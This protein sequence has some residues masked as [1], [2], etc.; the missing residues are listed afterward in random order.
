MYTQTIKQ[1]FDNEITTYIPRVPRKSFRQKRDSEPF[2]LLQSDAGL[3]VSESEY[4][5]NYYHDTEVRYEWNNGRLEVKDMPTH[6]SI[7]CVNFLLDCIEQYLISNPIATLITYDHAFTLKAQ[8]TKTI[9]RPDYAVILKSNPVQMLPGDYSYSG[10]YDICVELLSDT[11]KQYITKDTV[12]RK[13]E[14]A[15]ANVSEYFIVDINKQKHTAFYRLNQNGTYVKIKS[16]NGV[17]QSTVLPGF[18]FRIEDIYRHPNLIDLIDDDVYKNYMLLDYQKERQE[19]EK[20]RKEKEII[21][22]EKE[23]IRKEKE[24][25]LQEKEKERQEKE[26]ER[27]EKEKERQ[28]KEKERQEKEKIRKEKE[29]IRKEREKIRQEKEII[30]Q[31]KEKER[32]EKEILLKQVK[33]ERIDKEVLLNQLESERIDKENALKEI[34]HLKKLLN[35]NQ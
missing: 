2:I 14:Y 29:K 6:I 5:E 10:T 26:K 1:S 7:V 16:Q 33:N 3:M 12:T 11:K 4:W 20:V 21:R 23:I 15:N 22:K 8:K 17:I 24:I 31:E 32:Q 28:E 34:E 19:K 25:I 13:K 18:Q 35:Q 30:L 9:R 27:Q